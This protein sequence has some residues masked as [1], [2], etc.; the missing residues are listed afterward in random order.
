M[1]ETSPSTAPAFEGVETPKFEMPTFNMPA[2]EV[3]AAFRDFAEKSIAQ[4]R[5]GYD[6]MKAVAEEATGVMEDTYANASRGACDYGLKVIESARANANAAFDLVG[7]LLGVKTYSEALELTS[8]YLREQFDL[9]TSQTRDLTACAHKAGTDTIAPIK[10]SVT[11]A[12]K[13]AA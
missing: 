6:K 12:M 10:D 5:E 9:L 2:F 4:T 7:A 11:N 1:A 8:T 3:P 13:K